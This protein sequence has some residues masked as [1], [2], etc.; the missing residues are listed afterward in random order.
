MAKFLTLEDLRNNYSF[1]FPTSQDSAYQALL[2][3]AEEACL[4]YASIDAGEV[5]EYFSSRD[6]C[7][8]THSPVLSIESVTSGGEE[9]SYRYDKRAESVVLTGSASSEIAVTYICGFEEVPAMLK[10]AIAFTVQHLAK[11]NAAKLLGI[12]SR[13]TEGGTETIEQSVPPLAVQRLLENY[14]KNRV[15]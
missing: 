13:T 9:V 12:N 2:D 11:L 1:A 10:S 14:R 3:T 4:S 6:I 5:T 8:L 15:L 7:V